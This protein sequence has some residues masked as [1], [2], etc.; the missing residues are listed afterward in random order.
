MMNT[1]S[2]MF[3]E[4]EKLR[5]SID[6]STEQTLA[7]IIT[8]Y[9]FLVGSKELKGRLVEALP[10]DAKIIYSPYIEDPTVVYA[11]KK[12]EISSLF[13]TPYKSEE[14]TMDKQESK[15]IM[16]SKNA[17]KGEVLKQIFPKLETRDIGGD[18]ITFTL[19]GI[20]GSTVE[21]KWWNSPY[22][23]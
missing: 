12:F 19:D 10:K 4:M 23:G 11:I 3:E 15:I 6:E 21:K 22:E 7:E 17:T 1:F 20:V 13:S 18:F 14:D 8:K 9:D 16:I 2:G 5:K